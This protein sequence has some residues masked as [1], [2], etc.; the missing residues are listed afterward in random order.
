MEGDRRNHERVLQQVRLVRTG[1]SS[2][3]VEVGATPQV[4]DIP[5]DVETPWNAQSR[6]SP[7]VVSWENLQGACES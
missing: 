4:L 5:N 3:S 7:A 1:R 6:A 2:A